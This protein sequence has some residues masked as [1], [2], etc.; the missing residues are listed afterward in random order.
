MKKKVIPAIIIIALIFIIG[1]IYVFQLYNEHFSYSKKTADLNNYFDIKDDTD[2]AIIYGNEY[3]SDR[4][5]LYDGAYYL[6]MAFVSKYL[7]KRFYYGKADGTLVYTTPDAII[8]AK[9]GEKTYESTK[10][11]SS[12]ESYQIARLDDEENLWIALDYVKKFTNFAYK[13]F[14]NPNHI[15]IDTSWDENKVATVAKDTQLRIR[16]GVKSAVIEELA[17]D[18]KVII[19]DEMQKW[20]KVKTEDSFI[21]YVEN[22][23]LKDWTTSSPIPVTDYKEPEYTTLKKDYKINL[24]FHNIHG[25]IGNDTLVDFL[26]PS[27]SVN[28]VSPTWLKISSNSGDIASYASSSYVKTAHDKGIEVWVLLDNFTGPKDSYSTSEV[29]S[30]AESRANLIKNA[31][32]ETV[33]CGADGIN[34]DFEQIANE[35]GQSYIEFVREL[36]IACREAGLVFSIDDYVPMNFNDH[37]D[38]KEQGIVADYVIIMGYDEHYSGS[39]AGSVASIGYVEN[40]IINTTKKVDP[41]KVINAVPFYTRLWRTK[42][43]GTVTSEALSMK[44]AKEYIN[45]HSLEMTW[46]GEVLQNYGEYTSSDGTLNQIWMEDVSSMEQKVN[47]MKANNIGGIAEWSLGM[48]TSDI[49]D[50]ISAYVE[51]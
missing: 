16:G 38:I 29:L 40:G 41:S 14:T 21:G 45:N 49:W 34:L 43:D 48:E 26:A 37:Y 17:A 3:I 44:K 10:D 8:T 42:E 50:V 6:D 12:E 18:E 13:G 11:G 51:G 9:I 39:A 24:A 46:D 19:L 5:K 30:H 25:D 32:E 20:S 35:D 4:A 7:N 23:K 33:S 15:Q 27:K 36:S 2:V 31:V 1:G 28:V 22:K 47:V